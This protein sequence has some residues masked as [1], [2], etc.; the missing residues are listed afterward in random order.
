MAFLELLSGDSPYIELPLSFSSFLKLD[1]RPV[2]VTA[3]VTTPR[4]NEMGDDGEEQDNS[5]FGN[6]D[7]EEEDE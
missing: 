7:I 3:P 5:T 6:G 4:P 1:V 2:L